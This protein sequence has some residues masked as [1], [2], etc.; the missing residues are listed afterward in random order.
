MTTQ[1]LAQPIPV[2]PTLLD[3]YTRQIE[4]GGQLGII[5]KQLEAIPDHEQRIRAL[6]RFRFTLAGLSTIGGIAA[7]LAGYWIGHVLH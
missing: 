3:I 5:S 6:E 2:A 4:M 1:P 7:G